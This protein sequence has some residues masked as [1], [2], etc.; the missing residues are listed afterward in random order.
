MYCTYGGFYVVGWGDGVGVGVGRVWVWVWVW[1]GRFFI[2][3]S[4]E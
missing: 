2:V 1:V 4:E 3:R